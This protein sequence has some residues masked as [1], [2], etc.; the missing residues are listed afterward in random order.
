MRLEDLERAL[1]FVLERHGVPE[2]EVS[3][4]LTDDGEM[5]RL[6]Q[7]FRGVD[8]ATDVLT[9]PAP[10]GLEGQVGD[11]AVSMDFARRGAESRGVPIEEE[12]AMLVIHGGLHLAGYDDETEEERGKMSHMMN[13]AASALGLAC[14]EGWASQPHG[15]TA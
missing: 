1:E 6:N 11:I 8:E 5:R 12:A 2:G 3:V 13:E 4:L 7:R 10:D 15:G 9:F 14:D